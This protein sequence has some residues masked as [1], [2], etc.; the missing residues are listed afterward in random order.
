MPHG[1]KAEEGRWEEGSGRQWLQ[2]GFAINCPAYLF[3]CKVILPIPETPTAH[4]VHDETQVCNWQ[5]GYSKNQQSPTQSPS[6][7][8]LGLEG[9]TRA[10]HKTLLR[11]LHPLPCLFPYP[12]RPNR[13]LSEWKD[14]I[15]IT[16]SKYYSTID[17]CNISECLIDLSLIWISTLPL[18]TWSIY[19]TFFTCQEKV[20]NGKTFGY[21]VSNL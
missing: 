1:T 3:P 9:N 19:W 7:L 4:H 21:S 8:E 17:I 2:L 11:L 18:S 14:S 20:N 10:A 13:S 5:K 16:H 6:S 15:T 12:W